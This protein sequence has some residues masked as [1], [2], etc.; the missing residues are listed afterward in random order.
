MT[1]TQDERRKKW[2]LLRCYRSVAI[3][4]FTDTQKF[5]LVQQF[6]PA[7]YI[8]KVSKLLDKS[9]TLEMKLTLKKL[10]AKLI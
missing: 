7:D 2:D 3:V 5:I 10:L 1:Y 9:S 4:I 8:N 6:R